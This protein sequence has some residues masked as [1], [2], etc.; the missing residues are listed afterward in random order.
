MKSF[1]RIVNRFFVAQANSV[2]RVEDIR[3]EQAKRAQPICGMWNCDAKHVSAPSRNVA[4]D[5]I[6]VPL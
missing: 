2:Q 1:V 6:G 4:D 5:W 3:H